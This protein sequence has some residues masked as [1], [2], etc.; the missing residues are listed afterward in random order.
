M[1]RSERTVRAL[2]VVILAV[3]ANLVL[4]VALDPPLLVRWAVV[5]ALLLLV[6]ALVE[7]VQR[8]AAARRA[9]RRRASAASQDP[10]P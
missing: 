8:R 2:A 9:D 5:V 4:D 1:S 10:A 3:G 7:V 6:T